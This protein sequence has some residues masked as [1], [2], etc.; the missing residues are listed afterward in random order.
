MGVSWSGVC[1]RWVEGVVYTKYPWTL[2]FKGNTTPTVLAFSYHVALSKSLNFPE[3][4]SSSTGA[5]I[6]SV[7]SVCL[8]KAFCE[9]HFTFNPHR[10]PVK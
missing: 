1:G 10:D 2:W 5:V 7:S 8:F 3:L 6:V 9:E 4:V